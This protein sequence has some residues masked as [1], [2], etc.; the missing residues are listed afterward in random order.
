M[1]NQNA[2]WRVFNGTLCPPPGVYVLD[3]V[4]TFAEFV[5]QHL[6]VGHVWG[7]FD[8]VTGK[9]TLADDPT[10]SLL[11]VNIATASIRTNNTKRDE[12]LRSQRFFNVNAFPNMS[13]RSTNITLEPDAAWTV[14]ENL[15]I[16]DVSFP[17]SLSVR[18]TGITI[19]AQENVRVGIQAQA[20]VRRI[21][22]GL[23]ADLEKENGGVKG[24][25]DVTITIFAEALLQK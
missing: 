6:V 16:R 18:I 9:A 21:D 5:A 17:I 22:F 19:D 8:D 13:Y 11:E 24:G 14:A 2:L 12:D 15:T 10:Q 25:K 3:P 4:H 20:Y 1:I 23:L 7:Q